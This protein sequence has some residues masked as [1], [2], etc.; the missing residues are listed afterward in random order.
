MNREAAI[1]AWLPGARWFAG[2]GAGSLRVSIRDAA[3][4]PGTAVE[5][6]VVDVA[7]DAGSDRY[8]LALAAG[9]DAAFAPE[10]AGWVVRTALAGDRLNG[11]AGTFRG[12]PTA[13]AERGSGT[14]AVAGPVA[15]VPLGGDASNT[16]LR[17]SLG[18]REYAVKLLRR[19]RPGVQPEVEVGRFLAE[20][21]WNGTPRLVGWLDYQ[22]TAGD[23]TVLATV[24]EF[25]AGCTT[26]WERLVDLTRAG[27]VCGPNRPAILE[28]VA[29]IGRATAEL[30]RAFG[31]RSDVPAF[32]PERADAGWATAEA[33][34]MAGHA[35]GVLDLVQARLPMLPAAPAEDARRLLDHREEIEARLRSLSSACTSSLLVRVHGDYHLGQVLV[36]E[37]GPRVLVIDFEGEPGRSLAERRRKTSVCKDLAGMCRS[38]DYLL[39]HAARSAAEPYAAEDLATLEETFL[40]A[41]RSIARGHDWWPA[42]PAAAARLLAVYRLDKAVYELAYELANRPDWIEVPLAALVARP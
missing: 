42:D 27:G 13:V 28:V 40:D 34:R 11:A 8:W 1:A 26:A 14:D 9:E 22:P 20:A 19:C 39:R 15:V 37:P 30:H 21:G 36:G 17:V 2:K 3:A 6:A 5:A 32:A 33:E 41:Y 12:H 18:R 38:F 16:S 24:H 35:A 7:H 31:S 25:A 10:F 4:V 29:A 23:P